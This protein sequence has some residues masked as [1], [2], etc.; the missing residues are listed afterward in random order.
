MKRR[1]SFEK[2]DYTLRPA[3]NVERKMIGET[4]ARLSG[5]APLVEYRYVGLGAIAF[6]DF[7]LFHQRLGISDMVSMEEKVEERH[8]VCFN[9]PYSCIKIKWG[10]ASEVLPKL[11][12]TKRAIVWLDYDEPLTSSVLS[13]ISTVVASI[14]TGSA[15]IVTVDV[16][17]RVRRGPDMAQAR[18]KKLRKRV[19]EVRI[20]QG[21]TGTRL[22]GWGLARVCRDIIDNQIAEALAD[23]NAP[24]LADRNA[25]PDEDEVLAYKQL[26]NFQ[27]ADKARMLTVGGYI[28]N[29][30]DRN[31]VSPSDFE[32]LD[33]IRFGKDPYL[34][35]V[36]VLT[37]REA[38]LLNKLLPQSAPLVP[39]PEWLPARDR[40]NYGKVYR[41]YPTYLEAE[42]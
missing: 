22:G 31:Q 23:R 15:I 14:R 7:I 9:R 34:I 38:A 13:D 3:K 11:S 12:W 6:A 18:M 8:R 32:D 4:F 30:Q 27:Y 29:P 20:P 10:T 41:H 16:Q 39:R 35:E 42:I 33:F 2:F 24:L 37:R 17:D 21:T 1:K 19:D 26:F 25:P 36:P 5:I 40:K 28:A